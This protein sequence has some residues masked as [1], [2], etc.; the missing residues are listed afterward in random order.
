MYKLFFII[1]SVI[2]VFQSFCPSVNAELV[3]IPEYA[4]AEILQEVYAAG[5]KDTFHSKIE[6]YNKA[7]ELANALEVQDYNLLARLGFNKGLI[8]GAAKQPKEAIEGYNTTLVALK[9]SKRFENSEIGFLSLYNMAQNYKLLEDTENV[10]NSYYLIF[11]TQQYVDQKYSY[12]RFNAIYELACIYYNNQEYDKAFYFL[13]ES[14]DG[15]VDDNQWTTSAHRVLYCKTMVK[16]GEIKLIQGEYNY[17]IYCF[18]NAIRYK[19]A[20]SNVLNVADT[21]SNIGLAYQ[22]QNKLNKAKYYYEQAAQYY[23]KAQY[24]KKLLPKGIKGKYYIHHDKKYKT[25]KNMLTVY[26]KLNI[27]KNRTK[28]I[29][30]ELEQKD[31]IR[32]Q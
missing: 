13:Q 30:R 17:A 25:Y 28:W 1:A 18:E 8:A 10:K 20:I 22:L 21:Y 12:Q 5:E 27:S 16:M 7:I 11:K 26:K 32:I 15:I 3:S 31:L 29:E 14:V 24:D 9:I 6:H 4:P 19:F 23:N 2:F